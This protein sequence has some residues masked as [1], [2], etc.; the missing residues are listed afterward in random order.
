MPPPLTNQSSVH[1]T[2]EATHITSKK[3]LAEAEFVFDT[4]PFYCHSCPC[5]CSGPPAFCQTD[6]IKK[7][8][9]FRIFENR[10]EYN[11]PYSTCCCLPEAILAP[12]CIKD[13]IV[14]E[15]FDM[16][17]SRNQD[18]CCLGC[19]SLGGCCGPP[20]IYN[21]KP[22]C[23]YLCCNV[24]YSPYYGE[25]IRY[26]PHSCRECTC[27][28]FP[29]AESRNACSSPLPW[30]GC[31]RPLLLRGLKNST[32]FLKRWKAALDLYK[33]NY[34]GTVREHN[35]T[36]FK[37]TSLGEDEDVDVALVSTVI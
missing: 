21:F 17:L 36:T 14:T 3:V 19:C 32:D 22:H 10:L 11:E 1:G 8:T 35:W 16:G 26:H 6:R 28:G 23:G 5:C 15:Y 7:R 29:C 4:H 2:D 24:D 31:S 18:R 20:L 37:I 13:R 9:Y 34:P 33:A 30:P 12:H 27:L 25:G